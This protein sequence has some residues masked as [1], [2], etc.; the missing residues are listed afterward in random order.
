MSIIHCGKHILDLS[1]SAV[2]GILNVTPDSF[3]DGGQHNQL[4]RAVARAWQMVEEGAAIVDIGGE[5][6]RPGADEVDSAEELRR[7]I[8]VIEALHDLPVPISIDTYKPEV[9]RAAVEA[10]ASF[11]NDVNGLEADGAVALVAELG[12]PVCIMHMQHNPRIMQR[13][14]SYS[15]VTRNVWDYL[16]ERAKCCEDAGINRQNI[17]LDPGFGFGKTLNHNIELFRKLQDFAGKRYSTLIGVSRKSMIG[18]ILDNNIADR[19]AGSLALATLA[20][21]HGID[22]IRTHNV[23][24]TADALVIVQAMRD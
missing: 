5:S 15:D 8:P 24:A 13:K 22:I 20:A 9:M 23:K 4:K 3:S 7:V 6:T 19:D 12:V 14:P 21:W 11:I 10:G 17:V 18:T 2:M 16:Y 1:S